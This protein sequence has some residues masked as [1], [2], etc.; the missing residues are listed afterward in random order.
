M[1]AREKPDRT[2]HLEDYS[3]LDVRERPAAE[4]QAER[5]SRLVVEAA[6]D[7]VISIDEHST[8][9]L[10]NPAVTKIFGYSS[11]EILRTAR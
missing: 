5:R 4:A 7:A 9:T 6:T 1:V 3:S 2:K 11:A 10:V 8:I